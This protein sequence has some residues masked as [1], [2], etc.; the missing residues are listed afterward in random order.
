M[1]CLTLICTAL[2]FFLVSTV[3]AQDF[4]S[5]KG[6]IRNHTGLSFKGIDL[7]LRIEARRGNP[8]DSSGQVCGSATFRKSYLPDSKG[9]VVLEIPAL[10]VS[11]SGSWLFRPTYSAVVDIHFS[12]LGYTL[13]REFY[14]DINTS[15]SAFLAKVSLYRF[16][17]QTARIR[18]VPPEGTSLPDYVANWNYLQYRLYLAFVGETAQVRLDPNEKNSRLFYVTVRSGSISADNVLAVNKSLGEP[19]I[20]VAG[21]LGPSPRIR[22]SVEVSSGGSENIQFRSTQSFI[23]GDEMP[24][25]LRDISI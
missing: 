19:I 21:D 24:P 13:H 5:Q 14:S 22:A 16:P 12:D 20:A 3:S 18:I 2:S 11:C 23:L 7:D 9:D 25:E 1:K 15:I 17:P 8:F 6:I 4:L 10:S